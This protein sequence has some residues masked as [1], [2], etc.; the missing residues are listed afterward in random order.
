M[1][2][3]THHTSKVRTLRRRFYPKK[4]G[5]RNFGLRCKVYCAG[6]IICDAWKHRD[7]YGWFPR[8][9]EEAGDY[10]QQMAYAESMRRE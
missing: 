3:K 1:Q 10:S 8:T 6:C 2:P 5:G 9:M 7:V 4:G